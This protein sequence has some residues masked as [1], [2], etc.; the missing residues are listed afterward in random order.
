MSISVVTRNAIFDA[1]RERQTIWCGRLNEP[2][3]L[4]RLYDLRSLPSSDSRLKNALSDVHT[5]TVNWPGDWPYEWLFTDK[6]FEL[7]WNDDKLLAFLAEMLHPEV[8]PDT[9]EVMELLALI[10]G[11]LGNDGF[12]LIENGR[13]S[14]RPIFTSVLWI[15]GPTPIFRAPTA[16]KLKA[17]GVQSLLPS[18]GSEMNGLVLDNRWRLTK[19]L[20]QGGEATVYQAVNEMVGYQVAAKVFSK[21]LKVTQEDRV[22]FQRQSEAFAILQAHPG[23]VQCID[24]GLDPSEKVFY[25][26]M[27]HLSGSSL[28]EHMSKRIDSSAFITCVTDLCR[29]LGHLH[30]S[31]MVH[32]DVKP[33]NVFITEEGT[34]KLIDFGTVRLVWGDVTTSTGQLIGTVDYSSPEQLKRASQAEATADVWSVGVVMYEYFA[35]R[36]P[37]TGSEIEVIS[38]I[39]DGDFTCCADIADVPTAIGEVIDRCLKADPTDRYPEA[40]E[41]AEAIEA[42]QN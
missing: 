1:L 14:N 2:E 3:F 6:R 24:A 21:S 11:E 35:G 38:A 19:A 34:T 27:E 16:P 20:G 9:D 17:L 28:R 15:P 23:F 39:L 12:H 25:L 8:R 18:P 31:G 7:D 33:S 26:I 29:A 41:L 13:I 30:D 36:L 10:N 37:F 42:L 32:R 5:H 4:S 40:T 22:R